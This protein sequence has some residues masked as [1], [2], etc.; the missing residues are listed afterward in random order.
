M[1]NFVEGSYYHDLRQTSIK[2]SSVEEY[3]TQVDNL[4]QGVTQTPSQDRAAQPNA[5]TSQPSDLTDYQ[6][7]R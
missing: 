1:L 2:V 4:L 6:Q 7:V 5:P 3:S